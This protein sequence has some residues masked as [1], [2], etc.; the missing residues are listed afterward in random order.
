MEAADELS[1]KAF[2]RADANVQGKLKHRFLT[3]HSHCLVPGLNLNKSPVIDSWHVENVIG[4]YQEF[5]YH[6]DLPKPLLPPAK[7]TTKGKHS[8]QPQS[9]GK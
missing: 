5:P 2:K 8:R 4:L 6:C 7:I 3:A 9:Q 1:S